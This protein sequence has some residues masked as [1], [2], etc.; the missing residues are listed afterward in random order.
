M[1]VPILLALG[2]ACFLSGCQDESPEHTLQDYRQ[3]LARSLKVDNL[4]VDSIPATAPLPSR[5]D[6]RV[7]IEKSQI[8]LLDFLKLYRC[9]LFQVVGEKNSSLG[10]VAVPSQ[11]LFMALDFLAVAPACIQ[12][13]NQAKQQALAAKIER[14]QQQKRQQ[15]PAIIWN[16]TLGGTEFQRF[17]HIPLRLDDYPEQVGS[18]VPLALGTLSSHIERWLKG[19]YRYQAKDIETA[20]FHIDTGQAG[21]LIRSG[22]LLYQQ[23]SA[24][25]QLLAARLTTNPLCYQGK[26]SRQGK[27][28]LN[29][30]QNHL[31]AK[32][33][34]WSAKVSQ[35]YYQ[36]MPP[37][38]QIEAQLR[39]VLPDS[40]QQWQTQRDLAL[41]HLI[42]SPRLHVKAVQ[43]LLQQCGLLPQ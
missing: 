11:Q 35:R 32:I 41:S 27:I 10:K 3:R 24:A 29:V 16:A 37:I 22:D 39:N 1:I 18:Q 25:N 15:L 40:Y 13:L 43:P 36:I 38:R 2:F 8:N 33:Q 17:W 19:D 34:L 4:G 12:A 14:A 7:G 9:E 21:F 6:L 20:L 31:I 30:V 26:A 23:L 5:R 42:Q 28:L